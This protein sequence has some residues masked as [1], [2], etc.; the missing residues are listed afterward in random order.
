MRAWRGCP[1]SFDGGTTARSGCACGPP[2]ALHCLRM[3]RSRCH[4]PMRTKRARRFRKHWR[5]RRQTLHHIMDAPR[6]GSDAKRSEWHAKD[7]LGLAILG[8][9]RIMEMDVRKRGFSCGL[10]ERD[11]DHDR[12][13][14]AHKMWGSQERPRH[15]QH[16]VLRHARWEPRTSLKSDTVPCEPQKHTVCYGIRLTAA[17]AKSTVPHRAKDRTPPAN[18]H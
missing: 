16:P 15:S 4:P 5:H 14:G 10:S 8:E 2:L 6:S 3:P 13:R 7:D 1:G 9:R 18:E 11:H 17:G 12:S